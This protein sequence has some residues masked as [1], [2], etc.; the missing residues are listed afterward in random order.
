M[1][2]LDEGVDVPRSELAFFCASTGNPR[3]FI[4][5]RGRVLRRHDN[6]SHATIHDLIVL[7]KRDSIENQDTIK[8]L[9]KSEM[10]RVYDFSSLA[11]NSQESFRI[12]EDELDFYGVN[13]YNINE[14]E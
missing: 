2:C 13:L 7:P 1:K 9:V 4:Q 11:L 12:L 3:Q 8:G 14:E 5:R 10:T 6:K